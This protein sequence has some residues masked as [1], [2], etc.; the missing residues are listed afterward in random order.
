MEILNKLSEEQ[1]ERLTSL[2]EHH[3]EGLSECSNGEH[4]EEYNEYREILTTLKGGI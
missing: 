1:F 3:L 4:D 2:I